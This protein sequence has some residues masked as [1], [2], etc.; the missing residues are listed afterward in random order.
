MRWALVPRPSSSPPIGRCSPQS[1]ARCPVPAGRASW[2]SPRRCALAA[3]AGRRRVDLPSWSGTTAIGSAGPAADRPSGQGEPTLGLPAHPRGALH[4]L[5][6]QVS[7]TT[8]RM[9]L[10]RHGL[11][12]TPRPAAT[13]WR[14][15]LRQQAAGIVACDFSPSI[16]CG[17]SGCV[18]F[19]R[20]GYPPSPPR[21]R[22]RPS[23]RRLDHPAG[24][25][26]APGVGRARPAGALRSS[27]PRREV[28]SRVR[29]RVRL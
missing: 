8:I 20:S 16:R 21:W 11:D 26:P 25:Q 18:F 29:R 27:R 9:T 24:P 19:Y 1:A 22:D 28:L 7:A 12:P 5:G 10:R 13:T 14:A 4:G 17:C 23:R 2:S 6:V 15:F 3:A